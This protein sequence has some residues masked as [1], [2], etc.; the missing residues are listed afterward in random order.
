[1]SKDS[2]GWLF[3]FFWLV[4]FPTGLLL[5]IIFAAQTHISR[6]H[7]YI[8]E[9]IDT[10]KDVSHT[11][12]P[13]TAIVFGSGIQP[14]GTPRPILKQRLDTA[15]WL[16]QN[17]HA[18]SFIVSGHTSNN[19]DEPAAMAEYLELH[20][21]PR[22][23]ISMDASG[24]NTNKTCRQA[25][26]EFGLERVLLISQPGH[27]DRAIFLC[28]SKGIEAFGIAADIPGNQDARNL[29]SFREALSNI[30]AIYDSWVD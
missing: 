29:Q 6:N 4:V 28:R 12:L 8:I 10:F 18:N 7:Q 23:L 15:V 30:K 20:E 2:H 9:N 13:E 3:R 27:L 5:G 17:K 14:D 11:N 21:V 25:R 16:Y 26:N 24:D 22:S 1:M 19:Y